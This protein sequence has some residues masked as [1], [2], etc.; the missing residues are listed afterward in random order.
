MGGRFY[1][2]M[3]L[4]ILFLVSL[5]EAFLNLTIALLITGHRKNL[6]IDKQ[7]IFKFI[8]SLILMLFSS[9]IIRPVTSNVLTS[10]ALL[11]I[12]Y[13]LIF[14][15]VY[16]MKPAYALFGTSFFLLIMAATE[17][18]YTPYVVT[19]VFKGMAS[20]QNGYLWY[21]PLT[22][23]ERIVQV[24]AVVFLW[25]YDILIVTRLNRR[26]HRL[27]V[28]FFLIVTFGELLSSYVFLTIFDRLPLMYQILLSISM[29]VSIFAFD[30]LIFKFIYMAIGGLIE[31]SYNKYCEFED[32]VKYALDEIRT[33]LASNKVDEAVKL[34]DYL[35]E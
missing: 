8:I 19:Y 11:A 33:L 34:I 5:P 14:M 1:M 23:P 6:K 27:F 12:A 35:N 18:L 31:K 13:S 16:R 7:N 17:V 10:G 20:F 32:D 9:W 21:L 22:L 29:F 25:K 30:I 2:V 26:F 24:L 3:N 15:I 4:Y 28:I